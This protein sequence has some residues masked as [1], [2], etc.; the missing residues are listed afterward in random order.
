MNVA[1]GFSFFQ[2]EIEEFVIIIKTLNYKKKFKYT[3]Y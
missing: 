3:F 2:F 1:N